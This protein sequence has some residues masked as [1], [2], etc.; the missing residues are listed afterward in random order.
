MSPR[1][2]LVVGLK[3]EARAAAAPLTIVGGGSAQR[4]YDL[5]KRAGPI[6]AVMSFG[7]AGGIAPGHV[8]GDVILADAIIADDIYPTDA[9]WLKSLARKIPNPRIGAI[10]GVDEM[11]GCH[12][13]KAHLHKTTGAV[14]VDM[15]SHGAARYAREQGVPFI[16]L[17]A[18]ADPHHRALPQSAL[19]GM[20]PDGSTNVPAVLRKL[21]RRPGDLP[22]LILTAREAGAAM[23]S[24]L[25][26]RSL[27][28]ELFGFDHGVQPLLDLRGKGE[29]RRPLF[30][31]GN[32]GLHGALSIDAE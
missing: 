9:R 25:R 22:G 29:A 26:C 5:L 18:V 21:A 27:L 32:I 12:S 13:I 17:R 28:G 6:D 15:E 23:R 7:I 4:T 2:A 16:A 31:E 11:I 1:I 24:L 8:C 20:N 14:A 30:V 3:Q 10:A 19:V